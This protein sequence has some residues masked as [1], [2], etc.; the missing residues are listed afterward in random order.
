VQQA[1]AGAR[2]DLQ[3]L[4]CGG[5]ALN[6]VPESKRWLVVMHCAGHL[7]SVTDFLPKTVHLFI[8]E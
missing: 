8:I 1:K 4:M 3:W 5:L 6:T 7:G 2:P